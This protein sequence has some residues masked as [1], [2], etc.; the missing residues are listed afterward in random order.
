MA[1]CNGGR[2]SVP[3]LWDGGVTPEVNGTHLLLFLQVSG[4]FSMHGTGNAWVHPQWH[5]GLSSV[6][7]KQRP[8]SLFGPCH[9][10]FLRTYCNPNSAP[11]HHGV[12][13]KVMVTCPR[14]DFGPICHMGAGTLYIYFF[15]NVPIVYFCVSAKSSNEELITDPAEPAGCRRPCCES[16]HEWIF[17]FEAGFQGPCV[18]PNLA[19]CLLLD[20]PKNECTI[21]TTK[22]VCKEE[23]K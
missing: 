4:P 8:V 21:K 16:A 10:Y 12:L 3:Q 1:G 19:V 23:S 11:G 15:L 18:G 7:P 13:T 2:Y 9:E 22:P 20:I 5:G 6:L 17:G 14:A